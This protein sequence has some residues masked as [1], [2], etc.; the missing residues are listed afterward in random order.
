MPRSN[1]GKSMLR[2]SDQMT[3]TIW[4]FGELNPIYKTYTLAA[5]SACKGKYRCRY[6]R[7]CPGNRGMIAVA[8][9]GNVFPCH[10]MSGYYEQHG[11]ILGNLKTGS[12]KDLLSGGRQHPRG[13]RDRGRPARDKPDLRRL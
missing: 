10:Q 5:I 6:A 8:A 13:V 11:D 2:L 9:N 3:I 4:Q 12:L 7:I 1:H